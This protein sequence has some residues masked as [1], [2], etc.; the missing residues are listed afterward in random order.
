MTFPM[1][2]EEDIIEH[3]MNLN[4]RD[5]N[6]TTSRDHKLNS[7]YSRAKQPPHKNLT[8]EKLTQK[9]GTT[10]FLLALSAFLRLHFPRTTLT[11]NYR[12]SFDAYKQIMLSLPSNRYLGERILMDRVRTAPSVNA[13]RRALEKAAHFDM[14]FVA[15]DLALYKTEGGISGDFF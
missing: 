5:I 11:P 3:P 6:I 1:D 14:A 2:E 8:V 15:E 10:N 9:F 13:S 7:R 4:Q 12:D